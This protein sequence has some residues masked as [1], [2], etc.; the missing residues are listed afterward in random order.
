MQMV[1]ICFVIKLQDV[2]KLLVDNK[3]M[4]THL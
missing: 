4:L 3:Q 1:I 2:F